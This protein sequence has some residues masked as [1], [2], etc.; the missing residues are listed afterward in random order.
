MPMEGDAAVPLDE[1]ANTH[2]RA[3]DF[4]VLESDIVHSPI[5][6]AVLDVDLPKVGY[7]VA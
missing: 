2:D 4:G 7:E 5:C 6:L 3:V 1:L